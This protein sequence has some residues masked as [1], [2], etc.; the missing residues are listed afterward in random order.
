MADPFSR[1]AVGQC[2]WRCSRLP[3]G[4]GDKEPA[5]QCRRCSSIPG[6]KDPLEEEMATHSRILAW[7]IPWTKEPGGLQF[8]G[9][10]ESDTTECKRGWRCP[11]SCAWVSVSLLANWV[12]F[13]EGPSPLLAS[14]L[15]C[16]SGV[17]AP[18][19]R[20]AVGAEPQGA[21]WSSQ[22]PTY[23]WWGFSLRPVPVSSLFCLL[24]S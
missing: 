20:N 13:W 18:T 16:K 15:A 5:C 12:P 2:W 7:E 21:L 14:F 3:W 6:Q 19:F 8:M 22:Y 9:S 10:Q 1:S 4:L 11:R 23:L 17:S 24:D